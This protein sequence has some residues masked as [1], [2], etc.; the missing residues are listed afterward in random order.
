VYRALLGSHWKFE[1]YLKKI[2]NNNK[3]ESGIIRRY[4]LV[5]GSVPL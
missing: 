1:M 3:K 5:G 2:S 4:C